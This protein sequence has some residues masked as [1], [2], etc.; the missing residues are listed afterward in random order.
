MSTSLELPLILE[1][2]AL[3]ELI[4]QP[5]NTPPI[6]IVDVGTPDNHVR[7]HVPGAIHLPYSR[8]VSGAP[9]AP[10]L[11]ANRDQLEE[12]FNW[13]G[14][15]PE[16]HVIAYDDDGGGQAGRLIWTLELIGHKNFSY[17]NGGLHAW[18]GEQLPLETEINQPTPGQY[19]FNWNMHVR[20]TVDDIKNQLNE[21]DF[22]VWDARSPQEYT[23]EKALAK[24]NGHIPGAIN[25]EWTNLLDTNR[26]LRIREDAKEYLAKCGFNDQQNIVTH[27]QA[28]RR[29]SLTYLVG[30]SLGFNIRGYDGSWGEWGNLDDTPIEE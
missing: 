18:V 26:G 4:N 10:G 8:L 28:H 11:M 29:S 20:A 19:P 12:T 1:P 2:E 9:P 13:L 24:R 30:K 22:V 14:L 6:M 25:C 15:T 21:D 3:A 5:T 16:T 27:C 17:L 7:G 23:G